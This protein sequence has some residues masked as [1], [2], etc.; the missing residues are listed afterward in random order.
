MRVEQLVQVEDRAELAGDLRQRFE[1]AGVVA[2]VLEQPRVLDR[3]RD[4]RGELPE[5]GFVGLGELPDGVAE[6][7]ERADDAALAPQRHDELGVR[8]R[9]GFD[10]ARIRVH[11][12]DETAAA[13]RRRPRR[14]DPCPTFTAACAPRR[15]RIADRV[16]NREL[17]ALLI[18]QIDGEGVELREPGDELRNLVEQLV[19]IEDRRDLAAERKAASTAPRWPS[20]RRRIGEVVEGWSH[21]TGTGRCS[22][23]P[24]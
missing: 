23:K 10:V 5:D 15:R 13:P 9:H 7:V 4:V 18:E 16:G 20:R 1:G 21:Q 3:D 8:A 19:E 22:A 11:V 17:A 24:V 6:Q 12:V 2:R 14:P